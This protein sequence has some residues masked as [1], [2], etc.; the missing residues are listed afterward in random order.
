[1]SQTDKTDKTDLT[2]RSTW[3]S[4]T[5]W[6]GEIDIIRDATRY[7]AF[8][9]R[10]EGQ[11]ENCPDTGRLHFQGAIKCNRQVRLSAFKSWL[12]TSNLKPAKS[13]PA[14]RTYVQ[15][16]ETFNG[17]YAVRENELPRFAP[18]EILD[19]LGEAYRKEKHVMEKFIV[20]NKFDD[21][22]MYYHLLDVICQEKGAKYIRI[23]M[24]PIYKSMFIGMKFWRK[25][26]S[27]LDG[28]L[29]LQAQPDL[30]DII[31]S[32]SGIDALQEEDA[33]D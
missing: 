22:A 14:L 30:Q 5:S 17:D 7:P 28:P 11:T 4:V 25:E 20:N 9:D 10:V 8:V 21:S 6:S 23:F 3:W 2:A 19:L 13:V 1:M 15:K 18:E 33:Q 29:V 16:E 24:N 27:D 12:P 26:R 31:I 32:G